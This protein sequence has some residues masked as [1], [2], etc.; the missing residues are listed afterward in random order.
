M[1][2][3]R[4]IFLIAISFVCLMTLTLFTLSAVAFSDTKSVYGLF[5][6]DNFNVREN[7]SDSEVADGRS[8]TLLSTSTKGANFETKSEISGLFDCDFRLL[9]DV[10]ENNTTEF[11]FNF[12]DAEDKD[13]KFSVVYVVSNNEQNIYVE[14]D[15][16]QFGIFYD[17]S[18]TARQV[19][20]SKNA[21]GL[22]M[23]ADVKDG[24]KIAFD[25]STKQIWING[26][27]LW[28]LSKE[29]N[30]GRNVGFYLD[31]FLKYNVEFEF[32]EIR[33]GKAN[34]LIY[35]V[36]GSELS[37]GVYR[38]NVAPRL[39]A[40]VQDNMITDEAY[41]IPEPVAF[42]LEDGYIDKNSVQVEISF[43]GAVIESKNYVDGLTFSPSDVGAY[44][45]TYKVADSKGAIGTQN[46]VVQ[47]FSEHP[48][49]VY[50]HS[51]SIEDTVCGVGT[52]IF[53]P[54]CRVYD[55]L[56]RYDALIT[57][58]VTVFKGE[59]KLF[60]TTAL[61]DSDFT[62]EEVGEYQVIYSIGEA[63]EKF[64]VNYE[65]SKD[66]ATISYVKYNNSYTINDVVPIQNATITF[67]DETKTADYVIIRPDNSY[68]RSNNVLLNQIGQYTIEYSAVFNGRK[69]VFDYV[70]LSTN[71]VDSIFNEDAGISASLSTHPNA[72][73][74]RGLLIDS[75]EKHEMTFSEPVDFATMKSEENFIELISVAREVGAF[76][77]NRF[78]ITIADAE[79]KDNFIK[80]QVY[81]GASTSNACV[82][83]ALGNSAYYAYAN[84]NVTVNEG[85]LNGRKIVHSFNNQFTNV[86]DHIIKLR[87]DYENKKILARVSG[88]NYEVI[89]DFNDM[90]FIKKYGKEFDGFTSGKA[91]V[92][93]SYNFRRVQEI[94]WQDKAFYIRNCKYM[95][96][97][98]GGYVF[99]SGSIV[100]SLAPEINV[101]T[102]PVISQ[103]IVG[104][105]YSIFDATAVDNTS[106]NVAVKKYVF[107]NYGMADEILMPLKNN[108]FVPKI[109]GNYTIVYRATDL[110][111]NTAVET[112]SLSAI[113]ASDELT[114]DLSENATELLAGKKVYLKQINA[115]GGV[116]NYQIDRQIAYKTDGK[117]CDL[118]KDE[119][120]YYFIPERSGE[121][122]VTLKVSDYVGQKVERTYSITIE[123]NVN[124]VIVSD[125]HLPP[126]FTA[127]VENTLPTI[128]GIDYSV[129]PNENV[130]ANAYVK[131]PNTS[132]YE[133][134]SGNKFVLDKAKV[135]AGQK[136]TVKYELVGKN[137]V[138][139]FENE[140]PVAVFSEKDGQ[141]NIKDYFVT[142]NFGV[143]CDSGISFAS[144]AENGSVTFGK[145]LLAS[146]LTVSLE[147]L[148]EKFGALVFVLT[149]SENFENQIKVKVFK[150]ADGTYRYTIFGSEREYKVDLVQST[151]I[152]NY[153]NQ[154]KMVYF[155]NSTKNCAYLQ[156]TE[157]GALFEGFT[158]NYVFLQVC[159]EDAVSAKFEISNILNQTITND[160]Y[161]I[162]EPI[163]QTESAYGGN[164]TVGQKYTIPKAYAGDVLSYVS[165]VTVTVKAPDGKT[166]V[167]TDGT[168]LS[169]ASADKAYEIDLTLEG[170][171]MIKYTCY[172]SNGNVNKGYA[173][174]LLVS[175]PLVEKEIVISFSGDIAS[176]AKVDETITL[177]TASVEDEDTQVKVVVFSPNYVSK[178]KFIK[179]NKITL[180]E[181]GTYTIMYMAFDEIGNSKVETFYI[182]VK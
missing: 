37:D 112:V 68:S 97:K 174:N 4:K 141:I 46:F 6:V 18:Y 76:E 55:G 179:D 45:I 53:I 114:M 19:T 26:K 34:F 73:S 101:K 148:E 8:G 180:S 96:T 160:I 61:E 164:A 145:K 171:Y 79:N 107:Y 70:F 116:G 99:D 109:T 146:N 66:V 91:Y 49:V 9:N 85:A 67:H 74:L 65:V 155:S 17:D 38:E 113:T 158:S 32:N 177:P 139:S 78:Y 149:D 23:Q 165:G 129:Y 131:Y 72:L 104:R 33:Y 71:S 35:S 63:K 110:Y 56:F 52:K 103:A 10:A 161:D 162:G 167:A 62:F 136:L 142:N 43:E 14:K 111:G 120:G 60:E 135:S 181:K 118:G 153:D 144:Q 125:I 119:N 88:D 40:N 106:G 41:V 20:S 7:Y 30:D 15:G 28:D 83:V 124:P 126:V 22:Y 150:G 48:G 170:K 173:V 140:I 51:E 138:S 132:S 159:V 123:R 5:Y 100:D 115:F 175:K 166:A 94:D 77:Y 11:R 105:S 143:V 117:A 121:Y 92:S 157:Y 44:D 87:F 151:L 95:V 2:L 25:P 75:K 98:I 24:S 64:V 42:D 54:S 122:L 169:N 27:L 154:S 128:Y 82:S 59:E 178:T 57:P 69:I 80:I 84:D 50:D 16:E 31:G 12:T 93:V 21:L 58:T 108:A 147:I 182:N 137:G 127:G 176:E 29:T 89:A 134:I 130:V 39:T 90:S 1:K 152:F 133:K 47:A 168:S 86:S 163:V 172:D 13:N 81:A 156:S 3:R 36:L 102:T